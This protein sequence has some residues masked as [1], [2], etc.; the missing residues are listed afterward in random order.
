MTI[1]PRERRL[2]GVQTLALVGLAAAAVLLAVL[3]ASVGVPQAITAA[4]AL[5]VYLVGWQ[6]TLAT[7]RRRRERDRDE[8]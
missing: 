3:L 6:W 5:V 8:R 4:V 2:R 7:V 1:D